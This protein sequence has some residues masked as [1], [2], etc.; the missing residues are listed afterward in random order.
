MNRRYSL[1]AAA[2]ALL[3]SSQ[4]A[5]A[6]FVNPVTT[7]DEVFTRSLHNHLINFD[8]D[9][10]GNPIADGQLLQ[11]AYYSYPADPFAT[12][13]GVTFDANDRAKTRDL[14]GTSSPNQGSGSAGDLQS[15]NVYFNHPVSAVG[16]YGYD[17]VLRAFDDKGN[18][19]LEVTYTDSHPCPSD[20][21]NFREQQFRGIQSDRENIVQAQFSRYY[22]GQTQCGFRI[23]DLQFVQLDTI[24][25]AAA[26]PG[27]IA[28][29]WNN[30]SGQVGS[31]PYTVFDC[32]PLLGSVYKL[33]GSFQ[34]MSPFNDFVALD[35]SL[36]VV[37]DGKSSMTPFWHLEPGGCNDAG[38]GLDAARPAACGGPYQTPFG[39]LGSQ[40]VLLQVTNY[41]PGREFGNYGRLLFTVARSSDI[42][43]TLAPAPARYYGWSLSFFMDNAGSCA[44][45]SDPAS[46]RLNTLVLYNNHGGTDASG[47]LMSAGAPGSQPCA[48]INGGGTACDPTP[49]RNKTWGQLK[50]LYR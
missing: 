5:R 16:A 47:F 45:C 46:I 33:V 49:T 20:P 9:A 12:C 21:F 34:V 24:R 37:L 48:S 4:V 13:H 42:P 18:V 36:D 43:I 44:G 31:S 50:S 15:I 29:N 23:D 14:Y 2:L 30:C 38:I 8:K 27:N 41:Q 28:I 26:L 39:P 19:L 1:Y 6:Q 40:A 22:Q 32:D 3:C 7:P 35:G 25:L 11:N 10:N 17:F